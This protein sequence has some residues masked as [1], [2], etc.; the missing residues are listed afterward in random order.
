MMIPRGERSR[1]TQRPGSLRRRENR[2][3]AHIGC[4]VEIWNKTQI[5]PGAQGTQD[6]SSVKVG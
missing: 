5:D 2:S 1:L 4:H 6:L 3:E